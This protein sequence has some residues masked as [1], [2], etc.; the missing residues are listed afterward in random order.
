MGPVVQVSAIITADNLKRCEMVRG[1]RFPRPEHLE[2][3]GMLIGQHW[4]VRGGS[5]HTGQLAIMTGPY[6]KKSRYIP[7]LRR[8]SRAQA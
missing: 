4:L 5:P 1:D 7:P 6:A 2:N 3:R 8:L